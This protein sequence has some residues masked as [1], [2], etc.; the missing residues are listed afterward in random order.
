VEEI[1][2]NHVVRTDIENFL[3]GAGVLLNSFRQ[4][5]E[6]LRSHAFNSAFI[7]YSHADKAFATWLHQKLEVEGVRCWLDEKNMMPGERILDAL[8][9]AI[10][11]HERVLLC[12][13]RSS[14][15]SWWVKDEIRM[16]EELERRPNSELRILP[17][18]LDNYLLKEWRDGLAA[19]LRSRLGLDF[20]N[21]ARADGDIQFKRLLEG[22]RKQ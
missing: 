19:D 10:S 9:K 20:S 5:E 4:F 22:L 6:S 18:L 1:T 21:W 8:E 13:S 7:S 16:A 12:C 14:L 15:E 11:S 3:R 2:K 17:I